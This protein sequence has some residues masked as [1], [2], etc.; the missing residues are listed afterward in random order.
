MYKVKDPEY[1]DIKIQKTGWFKYQITTIYRDENKDIY[2][3]G[4]QHAYS[5]KNAQ[6]LLDNN[7][8]WAIY[9]RH[10][11]YENIYFFDCTDK[12]FEKYEL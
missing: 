6:I 12:N 2:A 1:F 8:M 3:Y 7:Y 4:V 11:K 9:K 5:Q 10:V